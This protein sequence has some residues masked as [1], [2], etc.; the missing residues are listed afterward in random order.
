MQQGRIKKEQFLSPCKNHKSSLHWAAL[1][2]FP[3]P[4]VKIES[5]Q[6]EQTEK[7]HPEIFFL[8][9]KN[10]SLCREKKKQVRN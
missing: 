6:T 7:H 3:F 9:K 8:G 10:T 1:M 4:C 2:I 5:Q